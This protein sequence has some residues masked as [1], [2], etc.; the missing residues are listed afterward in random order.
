MR[1]KAVQGIGYL[2]EFGSKWVVLGLL[3]IGVILVLVNIVLVKVGKDLRLRRNS[4][5]YTKR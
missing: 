4:S 3:G 5:L 2:K 1:V